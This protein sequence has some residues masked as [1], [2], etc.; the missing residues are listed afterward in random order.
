MVTS[1]RGVVGVVLALSVV[2]LTA[3]ARAQS[4]AEKGT[5]RGVVLEEFSSSFD[6]RQFPTPQLPTPKELPSPNSQADQIWKLG[7]LGVGGR[8]LI[9]NWEL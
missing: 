2:L 6:R 5:I 1:R 7:I 3:Q 4:G 9:G 8:A